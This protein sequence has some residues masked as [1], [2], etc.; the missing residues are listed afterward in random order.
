MTLNENCSVILDRKLPLKLR[1]PMCFIIPCILGDDVEENALADSG[2][3]INK[4]S[5]TIYMKL[6]LGE[7]RP[8]MVTLQLANRSVR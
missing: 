2:A 7:L 1:D 8:I 4:M 6:G 3:S 5:N